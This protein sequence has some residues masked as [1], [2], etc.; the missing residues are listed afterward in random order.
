MPITAVPAP[1]VT[2]G[3]GAGRV[4]SISGTVI[5]YAVGGNGGGGSGSVTGAPGTDGRGNGAQG[6]NDPGT[7]NTKGGDGVVIIRYRYQ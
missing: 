4:S 1:G 6:S 5:T 2:G 3:G 7:N